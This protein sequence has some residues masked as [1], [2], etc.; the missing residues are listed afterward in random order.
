MIEEGK[1]NISGG[2]S[3]SSGNGGDG[4]VVFQDIN[5]KQPASIATTII[6]VDSNNGD[7]LTGDGTAEKPIRTL[8]G[9]ADNKMVDNG[10]KYKIIL[11]DGVYNLTTKIF[12]LNC[13]KSIDIIGN[14]EKTTLVV[15]GLYPNSG[16]GNEKY[17]VNFYRLIWN[18]ISAPTNAIFLRNNIDFYNV[19]FKMEFSSAAYSY[20][21]PYTETYSFYNCT[22]DKKVAAMLRTT[23]G[24]IKLTNCYGGFTSGYETND[25]SW[26]YQTN[27]ILSTYTLGSNYSITE[28]ESLWTNV[29]TGTNPDGS[30]ANLGVY[31]GA[32]SWDNDDD[33]F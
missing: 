27:R 16:G 10:Y 23:H 33:I 5:A 6:Y 18:G 4:C 25:S 29:G 2:K 8:D 21:V 9:I 1:T 30:Q 17:K 3:K 19:V 13:D 14:K 7:D 28:D 24:T 11:K 26:D 31:G 20:F 12:E 15:N 32:Y 22:I